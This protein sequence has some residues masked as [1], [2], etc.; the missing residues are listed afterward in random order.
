LLPSLSV[1]VAAGA[2][3]AAYFTVRTLGAP[4]VLCGVTLRESRYG[5]GDSQTPMRAAL[6][7]NAL[8]IGLDALFIF[9]FGWGVAGAAWA[10]VLAQL[11]ETS[12]LLR[13]QAKTGL[14]FASFSRS[15]VADVFRLGVPLGFQ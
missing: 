13:A 15:H 7:A 3:A 8:N 14:G 1:D 11:G 5:L 4:I 12:L 2:H 6:T 9:G 10:T